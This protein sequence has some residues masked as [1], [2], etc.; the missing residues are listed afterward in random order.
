MLASVGLIIAAIIMKRSVKIKSKKQ[1]FQLIGIGILVALHWLT[2][3][4]AI[5]LSTASLGILCLSTV[6]LHVTWLD[7]IVRKKRFS[8]IEFL[9]GLLVIGGIYIVSNDFNPNDY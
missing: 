2:F 8:K 3:F 7:P 9:L 5:Q 4:K 6:T 1:L